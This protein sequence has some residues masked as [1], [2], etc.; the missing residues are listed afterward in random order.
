[1]AEVG[2]DLAKDS[3]GKGLMGECLE[4][5]LAFRFAAMGLTV[6][7]ATVD[8]ENERSLKLMKKLGFKKEVRSNEKLV[9]LS[10]SREKFNELY[11]SK[12]L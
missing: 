12:I 5:V 1:M 9:Y 3:W 7:D 4:E 6:I 10:L 11:I 2:Y 8:H